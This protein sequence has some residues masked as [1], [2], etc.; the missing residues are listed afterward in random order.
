MA[1]LQNVTPETIADH[2]YQNDVLIPSVNELYDTVWG[3]QIGASA[4][5]YNIGDLNCKSY[6]V[7]PNEVFFSGLALRKKLTF[8][9]EFEVA[10]FVSAT[11]DGDY[12]T[13]AG[14]KTIVS[15]TS[16]TTKDCMV[17]LYAAD[18]TKLGDND[19]ARVYV[20]VKGK[21]K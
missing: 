10:P 12:R 18:G 21:L 1:K 3:K 9:K 15:V 6:I 8:D 16:I 11:K 4:I 7:V 5:E 13:T 20:E 19:W 14:N 2:T 17:G